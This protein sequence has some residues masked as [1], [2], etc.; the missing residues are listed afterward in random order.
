MDDLARDERAL[1]LHLRRLFYDRDVPR[2]RGARSDSRLLLV[3]DQFEELFTLCRGEAERQ[4][5]IKNL[6]LAAAPEAEGP[7]SVLI[8][9]RADFYSACA[10]Y[11][12]LRDVLASQQEYIGPMGPDELRQAIERPA[13]LGRW[14]FALGLVDLILRDAGDEPGTLPLLSH[15]LLE[16][17]RNRRGRTLT[18]ESYAEAGRVQ[19]AIATTAEDVFQSLE[20]DEQA[21]ARAVF[22]RLTELGEGTQD[23]RRRVALAE[24]M[25]AAAAGSV[26]GAAMALVLKTLSDARLITADEGVV[27]VAHEALIREW[28]TLRGWLTEDREGLRLHRR[29]TEA[30]QEWELMER[31]PSGLYRGPRLA[32]ALELTAEHPHDLN[33]LEQEFVAASR[34]YAEREAAEREAQRQNELE[35][36]RGLAEAQRQRAEAEAGRAAEQAQAA[37]RLRGRNQIISAIGILALLAAVAAGFFGLQSARSAA[38]AEAANTQSA[39][40]LSTAEV[41]GTEAIKQRD[42]AVRFSNLARANGLAGQA[43][44]VIDQNLSL[45]L[46]LATEAVRANNSGQ[47]R[48]SM[49]LIF[50]SSPHLLAFLYAHTLP[51]NGVAFSPDGAR[52]ASVGQDNT[53]RLWDV[54]ARHLIDPP[55]QVGFSPVAIAYNPDGTTLAVGGQG[56]NLRLFDAG[57]AQALAQTFSGHTAAVVSLAFSPDGKTLASGSFDKSVRL[58]DVAGGLALAQPM[59]HTNDVTSVAFSPDGKTLASSSLDGSVR[60]WDAASGRPLGEPLLGEPQ[61]SL[62][63]AVT[64]VAFSPNGKLLASG[65]GDSDVL[66]WNLTGEV[67]TVSARLSGHTAVVKSVAFSP[68]GKQLAS[69]S[70]DGTLRLWDVT[71]GVALGAPL[72][73][74]QA[75]INSVAFRPDG[76]YLASGSADRTVV[77]WQVTDNLTDVASQDWATRACAIAGRNMTTAEWQEY[78]TGQPYRKTC[79]QWP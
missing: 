24:L 3:V 27:Q 35:A 39:N 15:A 64:S 1:H 13:K 65:S 41:A 78:L 69:A 23:T 20:P 43:V 49:L 74:H 34:A 72:K 29:L 19:G 4:A 48:A 67:P 25:P 33:P 40:S 42:E 75:V 22:L 59:T 60:L 68:D 14:D 38:S 73:G 76:K 61:L 11:P 21:L 10:P 7:A 58:W 36:A 30:A 47:A 57:T 79:E 5:F 17:W 62:Q 9:L 28:P 66:L 2:A 6:I 70:T 54:A 53:L 77:L 71:T 32:Q 46:L 52:L 56:G 55:I 50:K 16:T 63:P 12:A 18:L 45:A 26:A 51:V 37:A 31:D 8:T 44:S